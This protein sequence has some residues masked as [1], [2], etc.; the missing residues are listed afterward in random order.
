MKEA[1]DL[2]SEVVSEQTMEAVDLFRSEVRDGWGNLVACTRWSTSPV[3][4]MRA[5]VELL[6]QARSEAAFRDARNEARKLFAA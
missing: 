5:G 4:A 2:R 6:E 3:R 1:T